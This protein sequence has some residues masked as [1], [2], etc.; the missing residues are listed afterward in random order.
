MRQRLDGVLKWLAVLVVLAP[1]V[2][3]ATATGGALTRHWAGVELVGLD[4]DRFTVPEPVPEPSIELLQRAQRAAQGAPADLSHPWYEADTGEVVVTVVTP[5]GRAIAGRFTA[6]V[7]WRVEQVP[8]SWELL[9]QVRQGATDLGPQV[10]MTEVDARH[11]RV[12][13]TASSMG[14][15]MFV[16]LAGYGD[17]VAVRYEPLLATS[18]PADDTVPDD[19]VPD[20]TRTGFAGAWR[21]LDPVSTALVLIT[22]F[23][24]WIATVL[25]GAAIGR[26]DP[27]AALHRRRLRP[28]GARSGLAGRLRLR[29]HR[30]RRDRNRRRGA[31]R[32]G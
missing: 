15:G 22:G 29:R 26:L 3:L 12:L 21:R 7:P 17:A 5:A 18:R 16:S 13:L 25:A 8:H 32:P 10:V 23:P 31:G 9:D 20:D 2:V 6:A 19:T 24:L 4:P 1:P 11:N 14:H 27:P 30:T 28:G